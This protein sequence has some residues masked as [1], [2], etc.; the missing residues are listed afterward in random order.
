LSSILLDLAI[1]YRRVSCV[2]EGSFEPRTKLRSFKRFVAQVGL[3]SA[4]AGCNAA[5]L[6][7]PDR[8]SPIPDEIAEIK[9]FANSYAAFSAGSPAQQ[10]LARNNLIAAR[11]YGI[12]LEY[13]QYESQLMREGQ[14]VDFSTKL[15]SGVLTTAAGL[16]PAIGT[17]HTLS[18][19]ATLIN[20]LDSAYNDKILKSQIIQ[21]VL[22]SMRTAR[23]EQATVIYTNMYCSALVYPVALRSAILRPT[24][25][26]VP[27]RPGLSSSCKPSARRR[28]TPRPHRTT[29]NRRLHPTRRLRSMPTRPR[30]WL[31]LRPQRPLRSQ[32]KPTQ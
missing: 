12:D 1:I 19:T 3:A 18:E 11:M 10:M 27:F 8:I 7:G 4:V 26:R 24:I 32:Q 31:R 16:I 9:A 25:G 14:I 30:R 13:T 21:N 6:G 20:G 22:A 15:T 17:S 28:A 5:S 23:H 2:F 29:T